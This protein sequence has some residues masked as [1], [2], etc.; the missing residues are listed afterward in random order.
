MNKKIALCVGLNYPGTGHE[1]G[2]CVNDAY[3]WAELLTRLNYE[4]VVLLEPTKQV[5]VT[6]LLDLRSRLGF[7]DRFVFTYS[8]HGSWQPDTSGDEP[9]RRDEGLCPSDFQEVGLLL[10]DELDHIASNRPFGSGWFMLSDSCHSGSVTRWFQQEAHGKA[11]FVPPSTFAAVST[12]QDFTHEARAA[13]R[14]PSASSLI[15][16]C[17]DDEYSYDA[18]FDGRGNGAFTRY[19]ID[20]FKSGD[21]LNAWF[22]RIRLALPLEDWFPQTPILTASS[23]RKYTRAL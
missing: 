3:D 20:S 7:G 23:Y 5:L 14:V 10:D 17:K 15:S 4:V 18:T 8:G 21:T 2:G 6:T 22:K 13:V 11:R 16:G 1:L 9:D 12:S 19:A